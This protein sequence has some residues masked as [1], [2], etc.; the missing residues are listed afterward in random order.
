MNDDQAL[1]EKVLSGDRQ[2]LRWL[3]KRY[4]RL[5]GHV[6]GRIVKN[7]NEREEVC[8]D[9]FLKVHDKL[10][11]FRGDAKLSTWIVTIAYRT[12]LNFVQKKKTE[13]VSLSEVKDLQVP[14]TG[15]SQLEEDDLK[16]TLEAGIMQLPLQY[17]TVITLFH[18]EEYSYDEVCEVT[19]MALGTVKSNLFRGRK[20][21]KEL[22]EKNKNI[23]L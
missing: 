21:L 1:I 13:T 11:S 3:I 4:E 22:L 14:A 2:A 6:V 10:G 5:V 20:M 7:E 15:V 18:L 12:S 9:V 17:R 23:I 8:Q 19:G 16:R